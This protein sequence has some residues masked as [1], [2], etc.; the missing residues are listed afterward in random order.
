MEVDTKPRKKQ[1]K[2]HNEKKGV[3]LG[4]IDNQCLSLAETGGK[5]EKPDQ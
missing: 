5:S 2:V 4:V 3:V 1:K